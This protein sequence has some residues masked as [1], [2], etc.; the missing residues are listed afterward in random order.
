MENF[1]TL[2]PVV[3]ALIADASG[4]ILLQQ[5]LPGKRHAGLW[6]VPGGKVDPGETPRAALVREISEELGIKLDPAALAPAGFVDDH[7]A[8][9]RNPIV[10]MLY[11]CTVWSGA[12]EALDGQVWGWFTLAE[13]LGLPLAPLDRTLLAAL[14]G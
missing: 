10:L 3:A 12:P 8:Q 6:E 11:T 4:R 9:G 7:S 14:P 13:A 1:P 5:A 2:V